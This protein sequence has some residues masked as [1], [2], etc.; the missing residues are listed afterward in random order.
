MLTR[1]FDAQPQ[2]NDHGNLDENLLKELDESLDQ[3][4]AIGPPVQK[5]LAEITNKRWGQ[6]LTPERVKMLKA[7]YSTPGNCTNMIP[8]KVN[9]EI[10]KQ[11]TSAKRKTDLQLSNLQETVRRVATAI[12]QTADEL[13]PQ[14]KDDV[15][16]NLAA[17]SIDSVAML[18]HTSHMIS[19]LRREQIRPALKQEYASICT[20]E[21]T[22]APLLFGDDLVKQLKEAKETNS[23]TQNLAKD[24]MK[25]YSVG[26]GRN[27]YTAGRPFQSTSSYT[28]Y[29]SNNR[30]NNYNNK[31]QSQPKRDFFWRGQRPYP[32]KK[33]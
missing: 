32:R 5:Q 10:W 1:E 24:A 19:Q 21:P 4:E 16:K 29:Q 11:L 23:I 30:Y 9:S 6:N 20:A 31:P 17:R 18:G 14:T 28:G 27:Q 15:A 7:R 25:K 12:L 3:K 33:K 22:N 2:V 8:I 13:L 26:G